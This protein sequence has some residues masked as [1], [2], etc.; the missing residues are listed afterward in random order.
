[1]TS[2]KRSALGRDNLSPA[3]IRQH[4]VTQNTADINLGTAAVYTQF[5]PTW[6]TVPLTTEDVVTIQG[7][8]SF[9]ADHDIEVLVRIYRD[10][11][12][13]NSPFVTAWYEAIEGTATTGEQTRVMSFQFH[14]CGQTGEVEYTFYYYWT[15]VSGS[16]FERITASGSAIAMDVKRVENHT[17]ENTAW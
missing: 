12:P 16:G 15:N 4:K 17:C 13:I 1:M 14:D 5:G 11:S 2:R 3:P 9:R 6:T 7:E 8:V 10:G